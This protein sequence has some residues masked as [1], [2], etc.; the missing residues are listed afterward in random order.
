MVLRSWLSLVQF[1]LLFPSR[2]VV[3]FTSLVVVNVVFHLRDV[4]CLIR[5]FFC[6]IQS[7]KF[8]H[9]QPCPLLCANCPWISFMHCFVF[10][11][12]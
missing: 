8:Y 3:Q 12:S 9:D 2:F 4:S 11:S 10:V 1:L 5:I 6:L 7:L